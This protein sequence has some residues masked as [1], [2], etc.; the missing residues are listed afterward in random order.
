MACS[1]FLVAD[2]VERTALNKVVAKKEGSKGIYT[3]TH[4]SGFM[5]F[6]LEPEIFQAIVE[7]GFEHPLKVQ[8]G[9]VV[10]AVLGVGIMWDL[11]KCK[12]T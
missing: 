2:K 12:V 1:T 6:F 11:Q 4:S 8:R 9:F 3:S 10:R 7:C 5:V